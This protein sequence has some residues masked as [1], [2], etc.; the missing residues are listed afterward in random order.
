MA[1][2]PPVENN[3]VAQINEDF[4][5]SEDFQKALAE[6]KEYK[7][8]GEHIQHPKLKL[9]SSGRPVDTIDTPLSSETLQNVRSKGQSEV[10]STQ[11][12]PVELLWNE[13]KG[14]L[15]R[16]QFDKMIKQKQT[17]ISNQKA[18]DKNLDPVLEFGLG[19][20]RMV[21]SDSYP[22]LSDKNL[23][24]K[25]NLKF[26]PDDVYDS[27]VGKR[28]VGV[29]NPAS[30]TIKV[31]SQHA[32][33]DQKAGYASDVTSHELRHVLHPFTGKFKENKNLYTDYPRP[34]R[35]R[36]VHDAYVDSPDAHQTDHHLVDLGLL[37]S[38][39]VKH[40][41]KPIIHK[42]DTDNFMNW[43]KQFKQENK[44]R[45]GK[46]GHLFKLD[47]DSDLDKKFLRRNMPLVV[48]KKPK[49]QKKLAS[50]GFNK[51]AGGP[52]SW[53]GKKVIKP[54]V[55]KA[56]NHPIKAGAGG[57]S[58]LFSP[59]YEL[60]SYLEIPNEPNLFDE[61][62]LGG[63]PLTDMMLDRPKRKQTAEEKEISARQRGERNT[64]TYD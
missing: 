14:S 44:G 41:N 35:D 46:D 16:D 23:N 7:R 39:Y 49:E 33:K 28:S 3:K 62:M 40:G 6:Y 21:K 58:W 26:F 8:K 52:L 32:K 19:G 53:V 48:D 56:T 54:A 51:Q 9:T 55:E 36:H 24:K 31:R 64:G 59:G 43:Y 63:F 15:T 37:H 10:V 47:P 2:K 38:L 57:A 30:R 5:K 22:D 27:R 20:K 11:A 60:K 13:Y 1:K 61:F 18:I 50:L 42:E 4:L 34:I 45:Y 12:L 17:N 25:I 29:W